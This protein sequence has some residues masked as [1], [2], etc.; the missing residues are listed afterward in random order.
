MNVSFRLGEL[1]DTL[2]ASGQPTIGNR[3]FD[4]L[5]QAIVQQ[6]FPP[7]HLLSEAEMAKQIG[8]SRQPVREAFIKLAEI[9]LVEIRPQ[10]GTLVT[11][12]SRKEMENARFLREVIEVAIARKLALEITDN[13]VSVLGEMVDELADAR[14]HDDVPGFLRMDEEFHVKIAEFADCAY[15]WRVLE[16][17]KVQIDRVRYLTHEDKA[18]AGKVIAQHRAI[19]EA[20]ATRS[21]DL[22]EAAMRQHMSEI[23]N[24]MPAMVA[25]HPELFVDAE[26]G[27]G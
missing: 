21:P 25:A 8:V 18:T 4:V 1:D 16:N 20:L 13:E 26:T 15:A 11:L 5:R 9:G 19:V 23:I 10:R 14:R 2:P 17:L 24:S 27:V 12:I 6:R 3:V 22:A 7:G